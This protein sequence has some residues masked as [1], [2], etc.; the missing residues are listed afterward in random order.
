ML[1]RFSARTRLLVAAAFTVLAV[2]ACQEPATDDAEPSATPAP[3]AA[4]RIRKEWHSLSAEDKA[5]YA[6]AIQ[7]MKLRS[8]TT[9]TSWLYQANMH[10]YPPNSNLCAAPTA[11]PQTAWATCEHGTFFFLAWHRMYLHYFEQ[12][13]QEAAREALG[14]PDYVF[15][16][17]YWDYENPEYGQLPEEFRVPPQPTNALYVEQ[18]LENC[19]DGSECVSPSVGSAT[20]A[21]DRIPFCNCPT[22]EACPGCTQN[23]SPRQA[24]GSQYTPV[25]QHGA[26]TFGELESQPH[27][28][29][30]DAI[31]GNTGWMGDV[32]CAA[33]D[34]IFWLHHSNIDRLWQVWLNQGNRENPLGADNWKNHSFTFFDAQGTEVTMTGCQILNMATQLGYEYDGVPV[35]NVQLCPTEAPEAA[36]AEVPPASA[37]ETLVAPPAKE[38]R[39]GNAPVSVKVAVPADKATRLEALAAGAPKKAWLVVE[40][41]KQLDKGVYYQVYL[42]QPEGQAPDPKG[43]HFVGN[44]SLFGSH[45]AGE[46]EH[47][48]D[49][50]DE[51]KDLKAQNL[52]SG[53]LRVTFV[54]GNPPKTETA[55]AAQYVSFRR[56]L[57]K[58]Q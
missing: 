51:L 31:G 39:L 33:R 2:A 46:G 19:N 49:I 9:K 23:L 37:A 26:R 12:I 58:E 14:N 45:G 22:G 34:P 32:D 3:A 35:N 38:V 20:E 8:E 55:K 41:L 21:L 52:W 28:V 5:A 36:P 48:F 15:N 56:I 18:R 1:T 25:P 11:P 4:V 57:I 47:A 17:P 44:I 53:D 27:N 50:S 54:R 40:G 6:A 10:G 43:P 24:F 29:V 13:V 16:L 42:N 30:H 7:V